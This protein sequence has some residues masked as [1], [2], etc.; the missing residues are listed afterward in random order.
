MRYGQPDAEAV[1]VG[2]YEIPTDQAEADGTL[3]WS[4]TTMV[5]VEARAGG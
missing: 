5:L 4:S 2:V 1:N 3:A